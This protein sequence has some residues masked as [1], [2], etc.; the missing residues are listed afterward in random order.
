MNE[1][2]HHREPDDYDFFKDPDREQV[3]KNYLKEMGWDKQ[4]DTPP[5][6]RGNATIFCCLAGVTIACPT[7]FL[8]GKYIIDNSPQIQQLIQNIK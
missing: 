4:K 8:V 6:Q 1:I 5:Y 3:E 7:L 2:P